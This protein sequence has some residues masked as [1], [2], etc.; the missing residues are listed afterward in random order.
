MGYDTPKMLSTVQSNT[1][2]ARPLVS[3]RWLVL[4]FLVQAA[5]W[6]GVVM[7][8][9]PDYEGPLKVAV[10]LWPGSETLTVARERGI[11]NDETVR[12]IEMT[13]SS[14]AMRAFG[15]RV[16]DA[17][18]LSLDETLRLRMDGHDV[19]VV[20]VMD[21]SAGADSL[22]ALGAIRETATLRGK[23][24]GVELRTAG[25]FLLARALERAGLT[26]KDVEIVSLNLA[27]TESALIAG[28]VDAVVTSLPWQSRL[29]DVG[30][31]SLFDSKKMPDE[32]CRLLVVRGDALKSHQADVQRLV[33]A[34]FT[35]L[36]DI[37]Q[38]LGL[39]EREIIERREGMN[40]DAFAK[41]LDLIRSPSR[42][43][44]LKMMNG[45]SSPLDGMADRVVEF[46]VKSELVP[47]KPD[48]NNWIE[49]SMVGTKP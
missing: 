43:E 19:R 42:T 15:N 35:V 31:I 21:M 38:K 11:L 12:L 1:K 23:K 20:C 4:F 45:V 40:W 33:D 48:R 18:V 32:L 41:A 28:E 25:M 6:V 8:S 34:H 7:W 46:M 2:P 49:T 5:L 10:G 29:V 3:R 30:A 24:V 17:A 13:W 39:G 47:V 9:P 44:V 16:V 27:E 26:L 22:M 37:A 36:G 14:A